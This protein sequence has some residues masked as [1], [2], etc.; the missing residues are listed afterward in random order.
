MPLSAEDRLE[1]QDL[2][3][4]FALATDV[5][6]PHAMGDLFVEDGRFVI[7][8][9]QLDVQGRD[10]IINWIKGA[11]DSFPEKHI[12]V[13]SNFVIDG[14][15]DEAKLSCVSQAIQIN[16]GKIDYFG[17]GYYDEK[18]VKTPSGWRL[19]IHKLNLI[20]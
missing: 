4:R 17:I 14:D 3:G 5:H 2:M 6:G 20:M 13:L 12:H 15:G 16:D 7:D 8:A 1:I 10:N 9:M 19:K 18:L 11:A